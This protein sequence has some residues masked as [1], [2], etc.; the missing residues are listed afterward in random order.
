MSDLQETKKKYLPIRP[1]R[2]EDG[3]HIPH[4]YDRWIDAPGLLASYPAWCPGE[5][6]K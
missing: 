5:G 1:C 4:E 3:K 2:D 6:V